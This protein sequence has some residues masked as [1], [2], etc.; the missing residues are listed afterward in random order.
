MTFRCKV[1]AALLAGAAVEALVAS[2][3]RENAKSD[4]AREDESTVAD[5]RDALASAQRVAREA[6][7]ALAHE[8][9]LTCELD[10]KALKQAIREATGGDAG[11][12]ID[13]TTSNKGD[14]HHGV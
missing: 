4:Q 7:E 3:V 13:D 8:T 14:D 12:L 11:S 9:Q 2:V 6:Q 10:P 5:L 1:A